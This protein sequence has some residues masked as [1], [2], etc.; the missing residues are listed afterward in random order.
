MLE[1]TFLFFFFKKRHSTLACPASL[2]SPES[3]VKDYSF[4]R[5]V[6]INQT[7]MSKGVEEGDLSH[8]SYFIPQ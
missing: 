5:R 6:A 4:N 2:S 8:Q 3:R 1:Y 7:R